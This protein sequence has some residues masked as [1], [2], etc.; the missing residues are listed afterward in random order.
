MV[1]GV[2]ILR[3]Y[4]LVLLVIAVA[5]V[6]GVLSFTQW[7]GAV[8]WLVSATALLIA[9]QSF[10]SMVRDLVR[11][12]AGVDVLA[13]MAIVTAVA[14]GEYWAALVVGLMLTGGEALEDYAAARARRELTALLERAPQVAHRLRA[15]GTVEDIGVDEVAVGD[16]VLV[17]SAEVVPRRR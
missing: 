8:A 4:P 17:K 10:V 3:R 5:A 1:S 6:A 2:T 12:H 14:V 7:H 11:G 13:V 16:L 15:D 9:A